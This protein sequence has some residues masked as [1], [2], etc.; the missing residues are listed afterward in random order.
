MTPA[1]A[2]AQVVDFSH[3]EPEQD[4]SPRQIPELT[5]QVRFASP[6]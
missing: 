1:I 5:V 4:A 3:I 6:T 2:A